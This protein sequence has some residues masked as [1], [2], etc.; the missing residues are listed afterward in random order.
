VNAAHI[1]TVSQNGWYGDGEDPA[2]ANESI[3]ITIATAYPVGKVRKIINQTKAT[4]MSCMSCCTQA[5]SNI[6][7]QARA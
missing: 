7:T 3:P 1:G 5:K 6:P 4:G 2:I